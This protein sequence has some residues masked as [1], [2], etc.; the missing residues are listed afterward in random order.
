MKVALKFAGKALGFLVDGV[1]T[2]CNKGEKDVFHTSVSKFTRVVFSRENCNRFY[3]SYQ[4]CLS[5]LSCSGSFLFEAGQASL[6]PSP[7]RI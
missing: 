7:S 1:V 2:E 4:N 3:L 5:H 6:V